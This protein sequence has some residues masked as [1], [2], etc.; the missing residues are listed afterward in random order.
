M[1]RNELIFS[2][3]A[4]NAVG[5]P[6]LAGVI[7]AQWAMACYAPMWLAGTTMFLAGAT[8]A[9]CAIVATNRI[10]DRRA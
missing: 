6:A 8:A 3:I 4:V 1:T 10:Y 2:L 9:V 7:A 5:I